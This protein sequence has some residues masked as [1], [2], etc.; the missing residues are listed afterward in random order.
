MAKKT[1]SFSILIKGEN[2]KGSHKLRDIGI[3]ADMILVANA[4]VLTFIPDYPH[5]DSTECYY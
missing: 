5:Y 2:I 1:W 3:E 4:D